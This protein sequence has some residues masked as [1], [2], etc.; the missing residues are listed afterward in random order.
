MSI[1]IRIVQDE[2]AENPRESFDH[3]GSIIGWHRR[4]EWD[5]K[6]TCGAVEWRLDHPDRDWIV[7]PVFLLD[8]SGLS[9]STK[10]FGD[11]WDSGQ[12]GF[13]YVSKAKARSEFNPR[14]YIAAARLLLEAEIE[15]LNQFYTGD[16][17]GFVIEDSESGETLESC[18]GFYDKSFC[19][20]EAESSARVHR[21]LESFAL[22]QA[23]LKE[24]SQ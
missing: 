20:A 10:P 7:L 2:F 23:T 6:P 5:E 17:W 3:L 4:Y 11:P 12:I 24:V 14:R 8:H 18:C 1:T 22:A 21:E 19:E 16:V 13:I 15:E 9:I